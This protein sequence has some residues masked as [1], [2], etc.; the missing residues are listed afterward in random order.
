MELSA[1]RRNA[2]FIPAGCAHGFLT[3]EDN[4]EVFYMMGEVYAPELARGARWN[5]PV[6]AIAWPFAPGTITERDASWP[7]FARSG[8]SKSV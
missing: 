8:P 6:F 4:S 1:E 5:D 3:L 7:D 2:V